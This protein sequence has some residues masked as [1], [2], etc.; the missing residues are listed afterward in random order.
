MTTIDQIKELRE[1]LETL[2]QCLN[3]EGRRAEVA[4]TESQPTLLQHFA[5]HWLLETKLVSECI[6]LFEREII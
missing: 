1:R 2:G 5:V 3:M 4:Q 6:T